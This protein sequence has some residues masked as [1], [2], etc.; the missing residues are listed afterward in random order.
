MPST[1]V[2]PRLILS[3]LLTKHAAAEE[4]VVTIWYLVHH[5]TLHQLTAR[6]V[7]RDWTEGSLDS[8][9]TQHEVHALSLPRTHTC[10][11][12]HTHTHSQILQA[13]PVFAGVHVVHYGNNT[14]VFIVWISGHFLTISRECPSNFNL[15]HICVFSYVVYRCITHPIKFLL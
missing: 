13:P 9:R 8:D 7:I 5:Q 10:A 3:Q 14:S 15:Q 6:A 4:F 1:L 12:T 2:V 11:H